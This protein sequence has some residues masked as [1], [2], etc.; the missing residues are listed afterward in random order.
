MGAAVEVVAAE[1]RTTTQLDIHTVGQ[2]NGVT[3]AERRRD[4]RDLFA[5]DLRSAQVDVE[6]P[7]T[8]TVR[9]RLATRQRPLVVEPRTLKSASVGRG[10]G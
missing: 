2:V 3:A 5:V 7:N 8:L 4:D 10:A 6:P 1:E 9:S